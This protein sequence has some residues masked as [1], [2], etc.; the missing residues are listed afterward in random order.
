M[1]MQS[2]RDEKRQMSCHLGSLEALGPIGL[3]SLVGQDDDRCRLSRQQQR[4]QH[5]VPQGYTPV[6]AA[7][8]GHEQAPVDYH[9]TGL[10][11]ARL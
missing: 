8:P 1:L 2:L 4:Q 7:I 5:G 11:M 10:S 6:E 3:I 9:F